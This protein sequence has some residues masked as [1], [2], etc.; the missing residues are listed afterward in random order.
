MEFIA[1]KEVLSKALGRALGITEK[2]SPMPMISAVLLEVIAPSTLR[3]SATDLETSIVGEYTVDVV[4]PGSLAL[5][6]RK[7]NDIVRAAATDK[8]GV[9][10]RENYWVD[11]VAGKAK[12]KLAGHDP[13]EFPELGDLSDIPLSPV[14]AE[15]FR[16]LC[17]RTLSATSDDEARYNLM[18]VFIEPMGEKTL[19]F[20]ASNG[21]RLSIAERTMGEGESI[22]GLD[23]EVI[24]PKKG[25]A[26]AARM[27]EGEGGFVEI[28]QQRTSFVMKH[29]D[30]TM[31]MRPIEGLFPKYRPLIPV[32]HTKVATLNAAAFVATIRRVMLMATDAAHTLR[33]TFSAGSV[34]IAAVAPQMGEAE[35]EME[36]G[37]EGDDLHIGLNARDVL[38]VLS[39]ADEVTVT[40]G[41]T[42]DA[43]PVLFEAP[44][45]QGIVMPIALK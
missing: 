25:L 27:L 1:Q 29:G 43:A 31:A 5:N 34:T 14:S 8:I 19:R 42:S 45:F 36:I 7:L 18:G 17:A 24:I 32:G 30:V 13:S 10:S 44:G 9:T 35:E 11:I 15:A 12:F 37:Y 21:D 22:E 6:A 23:A 28:G 26:A 3:V 40:L 4:A 33:L 2:K 41:M 39:D 20:V 16:E 38:G